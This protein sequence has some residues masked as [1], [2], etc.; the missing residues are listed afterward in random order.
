V[1]TI[2]QV[3]ESNPSSGEVLDFM[4]LVWAVDSGL[5]AVSG[6]MEA[7]FGVSGPQRVVIRVLSKY[8][9]VCASELAGIVK[10]SRSAVSSV[11]KSLEDS[12][13]VKRE[14]DPED[15]RRTCV[16][17]TERGASISEAYASTVEAACRSV[18]SKVTDRTIDSAKLVL[19]V[20]ATELEPQ[21]LRQRSKT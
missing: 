1:A 19:N 7:L 6:E 4:R 15:R 3:E 14:S 17:L 20:L 9:K 16:S 5:Q 13:F 8:P 18:F 11:L 21:N 10:M 12:G 2:S